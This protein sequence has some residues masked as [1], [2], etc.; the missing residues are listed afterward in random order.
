MPLSQR[1]VVNP[2]LVRIREPVVTSMESVAR[3]TYLARLLSPGS[4]D[5]LLVLLYLS[6]AGIDTITLNV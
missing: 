3:E 4:V 1:T 5:L 6:S 2:G